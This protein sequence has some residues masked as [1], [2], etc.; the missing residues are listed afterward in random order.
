MD[1]IFWEIQYICCGECGKS[2]LNVHIRQW[3]C[4]FVRTTREGACNCVWKKYYPF[5]GIVYCCILNVVCENREE[6]SELIECSRHNLLFLQKTQVL[7]FWL[8]P[9]HTGLWQEELVNCMTIL[10]LASRWIPVSFNIFSLLCILF[11]YVTPLMWDIFCKSFGS[12][13]FS[14]ACFAVVLQMDTFVQLNMFQKAITTTCT[15]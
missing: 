10:A 4:T 2:L 11:F 12:M 7:W 9:L 3:F 15:L 6:Q 5:A 8:A 1:H 13:V 14:D